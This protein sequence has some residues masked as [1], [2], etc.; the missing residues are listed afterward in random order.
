[1]LNDREDS[2]RILDKK[3]A[4]GSPAGTTVILRFANQ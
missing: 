1:M 4:D 2:I 3:N